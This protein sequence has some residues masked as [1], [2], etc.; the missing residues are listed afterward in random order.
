[1][2][3][4]MILIFEYEFVLIIKGCGMFQCSLNFN[5]TASHIVYITQINNREDEDYCIQPMVMLKG[6]AGEVTG[7]AWCPSDLSKVSIW[8]HM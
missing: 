2:S 6:Q 3:S 1:M 7:V 4:F 8:Y 5:T